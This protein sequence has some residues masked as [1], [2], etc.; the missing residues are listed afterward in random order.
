MKPKVYVETTIVSYLAALPSRDIV[1]AAHQQLTREWWDR[2]DRFE[3]FV[4]QAVVDEATRGNAAAAARRMSLLAGIPL[5]ALGGEVDEFANPP[6]MPTIDAR[7]AADRHADG[8][9]RYRVSTGNLHQQLAGVRIGKE[10]LGVNLEPRCS[11]A[12]G[13]DFREVR[14][15]QPDTSAHHD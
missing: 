12:R 15:S 14:K 4:S 10:I 13:N 1:V 3:L 5:L 8:V 7:G 2:R 9:D 6:E 11:W